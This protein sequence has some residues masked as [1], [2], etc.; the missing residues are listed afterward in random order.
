MGAHF[1]VGIGVQMA[2]AALAGRDVGRH[3][4]EGMF[5]VDWAVADRASDA[6][7]AP[8]A[9]VLL[10]ASGMAG[11]ALAGLALLLPGSLECQ[12]AGGL[13]VLPGL[14]AFTR[15][16]VTALAVIGDRLL[17]DFLGLGGSNCA[18]ETKGDCQG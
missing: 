15:N 9:A 12:V 6:F 3:D 17:S 7:H 13:A 4:A 1:P 10:V 18:A 5:L 14:P 11:H 8:L 16:L 2:L